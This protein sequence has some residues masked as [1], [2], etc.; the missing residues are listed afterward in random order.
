M[1]VVVYQVEV[2]SNCNSLD[3]F[4]EAVSERA[5]VVNETQISAIVI[6]TTEMLQADKLRNMALSFFGE[7]GYIINELGLLG[8]FK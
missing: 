7:D 8:P 2:F 6:A 3:G 5:I 4:I 1:F